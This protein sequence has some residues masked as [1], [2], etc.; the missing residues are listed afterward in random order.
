MNR[1]NMPGFTAERAIYKTTA[2]CYMT[3]AFDCQIG[4][5]NV[6]PAAKR[7]CRPLYHL[8]AEAQRHGDDLWAEFFFSAWEACVGLS[9]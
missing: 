4:S 6:Q 9:D 2:H 3:A 7:Y 1:I 5:A 8:G